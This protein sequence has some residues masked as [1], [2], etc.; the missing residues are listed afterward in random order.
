M[1]A[2]ITVAI[3]HTAAY[4]RLVDRLT[5]TAALSGKQVKN[6]ASLPSHV[7]KLCQG[8]IKSLLSDIII[9]KFTG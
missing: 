4:S 5:L 3:S 8:L 1:L 9:V 2:H 6:L 7:L